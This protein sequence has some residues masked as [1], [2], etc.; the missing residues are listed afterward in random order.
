MHIWTQKNF[1]TKLGRWILSIRTVGTCLDN[2]NRSTSELLQTTCSSFPSLSPTIRCCH[3]HCKGDFA[4]GTYPTENGLFS[5]PS[6]LVFW[7]TD[8][9]TW[10]SVQLQGP[11]CKQ[12]VRS[13]DHAGSKTASSQE[14]WSKLDLRWSWNTCL[15]FG[16]Y[17]YP[18]KTCSKVPWSCKRKATLMYSVTFNGLWVCSC[19]VLFTKQLWF[20]FCKLV[21]TVW[22][23]QMLS[24]I[25]VR[26]VAVLILMLIFL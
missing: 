2:L 10:V 4:Q 20:L 1:V 14:T 19:V 12:A 25:V 17:F 22:P 15:N 11:G 9:L 24:S 13:A 23:G 5:S 16:L 7:Q 3:P 21:P 26:A 6:G 8:G 18:L